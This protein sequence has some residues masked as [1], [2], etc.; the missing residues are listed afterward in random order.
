MKKAAIII[1]TYNEV[2]NI[3][4]VIEQIFTASKHASNWEI[5][6]VVVD[7][8][9][10]DRTDSLVEKLIKTYPRLY[11]L[12]TQKEGLGKAY[13]EGFKMALTKLQPYILFE[14]DADLSHDP[15][16]IPTFLHSVEKGADFV[17]GS[18]YIKGGSIPSNWG[19]HRKILSSLGNFVIRL[20]FMRFFISDWTSGFRAIKSWIVREAFNHVDK[21]TGYVFQVALL[22]FAVNKNAHITEIP[23]N[24]IDR[25]A[26]ASKINSFQ[27]SIQTI[28]YTFTHSSFVKFVMV[29]LFGFAVDFGFAYLFIN[30]VRVAKAPANMLSAEIAIVFNFMINNFWSFRHKKIVGGLFAYIKKFLLFNTVS[31]GSVLIQG[32]GLAITLKLFGDK[33][34]NLF[35]YMNLQSWILYKVVI[36]AFIIIPYSYVLYNKVVWKN[37]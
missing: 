21:Y 34:I 10:P 14:M 2:K 32:A 25:T 12:K 16:L 15:T 20:G 19:L 13:I 6:V 31:L 27:Y 11:L 35:G 4:E 36:I 18:R 8:N 9:S 23:I 3:K 26:G 33:Q 30:L 7:S 28:W 22:D 1:P 24:F 37:K 29:G 17:I 5:H